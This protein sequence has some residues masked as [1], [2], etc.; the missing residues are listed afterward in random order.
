VSRV[1]ALSIEGELHSWGFAVSP[2][3]RSFLYT[4]W[5]KPRSDIVLVENFR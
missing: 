4:V 3:E 2:D 1:A 5:P